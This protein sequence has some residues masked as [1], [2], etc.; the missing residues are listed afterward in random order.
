MAKQSSIQSELFQSLVELDI[1]GFSIDLHNEYDCTSFTYN[2]NVNEFQLNFKSINENTIYPLVALKF[3][4][5]TF[6]KFNVGLA[7]TPR[8]RT[9]DSIYRGRF[10][11]NGDLHEYTEDGRPFYYLDFLETYSFQFFSKDLVIVV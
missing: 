10:E 8:S 7:T 3:E 4:Q 5:V 11:A 1:N 2:S 6:H 9:I